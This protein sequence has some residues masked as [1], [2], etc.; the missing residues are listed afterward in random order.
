MKNAIIIFLI[1]K[2]GIHERRKVLKEAISDLPDVNKQDMIESMLSA[3]F[4]KKH[5]HLNPK[6]KAA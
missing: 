5:I 3:Y 1:K 6:K 2:L 4:P